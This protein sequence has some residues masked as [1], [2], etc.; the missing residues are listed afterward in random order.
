LDTE[1]AEALIGSWDWKSFLERAR[2]DQERRNATSGHSHPA[3]RRNPL[4]AE[5]RMMTPRLP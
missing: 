3:Q 2:E 4:C 1:G 5:T